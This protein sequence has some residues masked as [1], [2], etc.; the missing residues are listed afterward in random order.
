MYIPQDNVKSPLYVVTAIFNSPRYKIRY[1]HYREF[2]K[3]VRDA[4]QILITVE[5]TFGERTAALEDHAHEH[6]TNMHDDS[7]QSHGPTRHTPGARMPASREHQ[8][9]IKIPVHQ[10]S[11]IWLKENLLNIATQ[12]LPPDWKY[13]AYVDAD[14]GFTRPDWPSETL[15]ALQHYHVVQMFSAAVNLGPE[16]M[17]M[18]TNLGFG[19]CH[20]HNYPRDCSGDHYIRGTKGHPNTWHTGFAWAWR[21]EALDAVGGLIEHG[22]L[23]AGD[24]HMA[25]ALVGRVEESLN[26]KLSEGYKRRV[27]QWADRAMR[28]I[29]GN[30]GYIDGSINHYWH[31]RITNR[32]YGDR[33]KLLISHAFDPDTDIKYDSRGV[34]RL[35]DQKP[36]LR[37]DIRRYFRARSE[38]SIDA[39]GGDYR[40]T[41]PKPGFTP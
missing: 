11:E 36:A 7:F 14:V 30:V 15:H 26:P 19:Y 1:K 20:H 37:D 32:R 4:G 28:H 29:K 5:G 6:P 3:R 40:L 35:T 27:R 25:R 13:V 23:G 22:I 38:D 33:W 17:P 9:Y 12:H 8:E 34:M 2:A 41:G 18:E 31:G 21:R 39:P 10:Q 24:N 16:Y